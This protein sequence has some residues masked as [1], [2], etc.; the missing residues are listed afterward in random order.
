MAIYEGPHNPDIRIYEWIQ[1]YPNIPFR[2]LRYDPAPDVLDENGNYV[3]GG[4]GTTT[5]MFDSTQS[6]DI[7]F[8]LYRRD[9]IAVNIGDDEIPELEY[10]PDEYYYPEM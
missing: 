8:D 9:I 6:G 4:E 5:V 1:K 3:C 2:V 7:P 10:L